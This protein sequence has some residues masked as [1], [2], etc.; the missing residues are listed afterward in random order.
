MKNINSKCN[1]F[2]IN[3]CLGVVLDLQKFCKDSTNS[4]LVP[5][6]ISPKVIILYHYGKLVITKP[7]TLVYYYK[8][9]SRFHSVFSSFPRV[10]FLFQDSLQY[11]TLHLVITFLQSSLVCDS[12][13]IFPCFEMQN[14][15]CYLQPEVK[16][17]FKN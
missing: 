13:S 12:F 14:F 1:D 10:Y 3:F 5:W 6:S 9:D 2:K 17:E 11:T 8:L 15:L 16:L 4:P 7:L